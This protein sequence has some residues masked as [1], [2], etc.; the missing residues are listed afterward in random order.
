[1]E[2]VLANEYPDASHC[3]SLLE[4]SESESEAGKPDLS[5]C[6]DIGTGSQSLALYK[7]QHLLT[8]RWA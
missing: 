5:Q 4:P 2:E 6:L 1:V 3:Q 7:E 8:H